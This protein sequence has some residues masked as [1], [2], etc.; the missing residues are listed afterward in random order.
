MCN[1]IPVIEIFHYLSVIC[2]I[3][4][5]K[6]KNGNSVSGSRKK[7]V[8]RYINNLDIEFGE[9][10][11]KFLTAPLDIKLIAGEDIN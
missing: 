1:I 9:N 2:I 4:A 5:E 3:T 6:D 11:K 7:K 10:I 8:A